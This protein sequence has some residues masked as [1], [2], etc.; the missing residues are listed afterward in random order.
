MPRVHAL[1]RASDGAL[2]KYGSPELVELCSSMCHGGLRGRNVW[3]L[4]ANIPLS[5]Q[6]VFQPQRA[7][8]L[9]RLDVNSSKSDWMSLYIDCNCLVIVVIFF[10]CDYT[11]AVHLSFMVFLRKSVR[12]WV[13]KCEMGHKCFSCGPWWNFKLRR[14]RGEATSH[15]QQSSTIKII[16]YK[17]TLANKG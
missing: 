3:W 10:Y 2:G 6:T 15:Y 4:H 12:E 13:Y 17:T 5:C 14:P 9:I 16:N 8:S 1:T 7:F 11:V